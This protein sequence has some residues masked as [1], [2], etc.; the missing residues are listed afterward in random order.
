MFH[1][2]V[3]LGELHVMSCVHLTSDVPW[4]LSPAFHLIILVLLEFPQ[5]LVRSH[6]CPEC[7]CHMRKLT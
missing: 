3:L 5:Q 1:L 2:K 4:L 7:W 6:I